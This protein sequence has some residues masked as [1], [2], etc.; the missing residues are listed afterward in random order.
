MAD[1]LNA[2]S[3]A[4]GRTEHDQMAPPSQASSPWWK[5]D[6]PVCAIGNRQNWPIPEGSAR[7]GASM[8]GGNLAF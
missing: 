6:E 7:S 1:A 8:G 5:S 3:S 4:G 2:L